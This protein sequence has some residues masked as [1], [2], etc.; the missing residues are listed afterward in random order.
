M[1]TLK[2]RI[3][4]ALAVKDN[5]TIGQNFHVGPGSRLWAPSKLEIGDDV[6]IGKRCTIEID[7]T[8]GDGTMI[9][10]NVGVIGRRDHD[11][12]QIGYTIRESRWVGDYPQALS[13]AVSIGCDVWIGYGAIILSGV[14]IGDSAIIGA[15]SVVTTDVRPN[16]VAVGI[17]A[18]EQSTR[19]GAAQLEDHWHKLR[20][21]GVRLKYDRGAL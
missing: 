5:V 11:S 19:F 7:G 13:D 14:T 18:R 1:M 15:G 3:L 9:A 12:S 17:P 4:R 6:Y 20:R 10:N 21:K 2:T 8:I 16:S